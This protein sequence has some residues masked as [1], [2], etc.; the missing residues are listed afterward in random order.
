[1]YISKDSTL[2]A[3]NKFKTKSISQVQTFLTEDKM[4]DL[5]KLKAFAHDYV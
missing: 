3:I 2:K 1:M 5:Y 4:L